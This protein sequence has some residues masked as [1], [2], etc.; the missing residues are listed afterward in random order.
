LRGDDATETCDDAFFP[1]DDAAGTPD[2]ATGKAEAKFF[3]GDFMNGRADEYAEPANTLSL[4][5]HDGC[6]IFFAPNA[7]PPRSPLRVFLSI[8]RARRAE[9][10][11][12]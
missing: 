9:H 11:L 2:D 6:R 8:F 4:L 5:Y 7:R 12:P 3:W 10:C 1:G